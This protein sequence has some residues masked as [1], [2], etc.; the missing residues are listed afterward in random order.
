[1][2]FSKNE[3]INCPFDNDYFPIVKSLLFTIV[4]LGFTPKISEN[5]NS[6]EARIKGLRKL[7]EDSKFSVHDLSRIQLNA[8]N[9]PRFNMP[10]ECGI[11]FGSKFFGSNR[12]K[13]KK[14]L[15]LD[16]ERY[17]FQEFISDIAGNDIR[18]HHD[19]P[20]IAVKCLRDWL[21]LNTKT[22]LP[23]HK[24]IWLIFKE[25]E[26]DYNEVLGSEGYDPLDINAIS[27]SEIVEI[28]DNWI[29]KLK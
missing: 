8:N 5:Y 29:T 12:L 9:F 11:D 14:F 16:K 19:S 23:R 27:F 7:I 15:I 2:A 20:E 10:F 18:A 24:A 28:M 22:N 4:Y 1:M 13:R 25:F 3:F 6:G 26:S 21:Y 17:R